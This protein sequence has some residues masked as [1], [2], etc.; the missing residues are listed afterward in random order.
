MFWLSGDGYAKQISAF[1]CSIG[2]LASCRDPEIILEVLNFLLC[3]EVLKIFGV[4]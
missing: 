2:S 1:S 3:S 4:H